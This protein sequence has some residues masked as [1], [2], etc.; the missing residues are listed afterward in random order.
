MQKKLFILIFLLP[1]F[2]LRSEEN[3]T[4][5]SLQ[6][7]ALAEA[8]DYSA[9]SKIYE[10]LL[11]LSLP[12]WQQA[13]LFYNLGTIRLAQQQPIE[14]LEFFQKINP[15]DLSLPYFGGNLFL[16]EGISYLQFAQ[17]ASPDL[18]V[19]FIEQSLKA[20]DQA[21]RLECLVQKEETA[22]SCQFSLLLDQWIKNAHQQLHS[23][24][25]QKY[26]D[27]KENRDKNSTTSQNNQDLQQA[28]IDYELLLLQETLTIDALEKLIP[29]FA[30]LKVEK[31]QTASLEQIKINLQKSL[32][33][34]KANKPAQARF[35]LLA[36]FS[37]IHSLINT[38]DATPI[39]ILRQALDQA[40]RTLQMV[41]IS[42]TIPENASHPAQVRAILQNQQRNILSQA[43]S[44][45]PS[46]L[47][48]QSIDY[49]QTKAEKTSCQQS[50][51]DQVI[52]L[53]D[54]GYRSAQSADKEF[55]QS[56]FNSEV[57]IS[58]QEQTIQDWQQA[59]KILLSPPQ[60][61]PT[62]STSQKLTD[63]F[64]LI[65][66]MYLQDQA[67]PEQKIEDMHSW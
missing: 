15:S 47:T 59:L 11:S 31:E 34:L 64:G 56:A 37:P 16:N 30:A 43:S 42:K 26:Q 12:A 39:T 60:P 14:A 25:Q 23:V 51:W 45:I 66:E 32:E 35:F 20:F 8:R 10:Q 50:P 19:I 48:A 54:R 58:N 40:Q 9:A 1:L 24:Y 5:L 27:W 21:H 49:N 53:F 29:Q 36:G 22:S 63:T 18:Q 38:K 6:A 67:Q 4:S 28:L 52:P 61:S 3:F 57:I 13:R 65:Q 7:E 33:E 62:S 44:F 55:N 17:K 46:V 2:S 41:L